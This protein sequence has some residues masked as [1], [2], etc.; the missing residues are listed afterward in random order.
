MLTRGRVVPSAKKSPLRLFSL[1]FN[2][3][4]RNKSS[5]T[6]VEEALLPRGNVCVAHEK[7][8][9]LFSLSGD[10]DIDKRLRT[11]PGVPSLAPSLALELELS[12]N[13]FPPLIE[14]RGVVLKFLLILCFVGDVSP[15]IFQLSKCS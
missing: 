3:N 12:E 15:F 7:F 2:F 8:L 11:L 9:V 4:C 13:L 14:A 6:S 1:S 5:G 10:R